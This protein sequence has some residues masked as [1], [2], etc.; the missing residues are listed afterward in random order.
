MQST[1]HIDYE[2]KRHHDLRLRWIMLYV[3]TFS[4][5]L[6]VLYGCQESLPPYEDPRNVLKATISGRY[7]LSRSENTIKIHLNIVNTFDETFE[8]KGIFEGTGKLIS[9]RNKDFVHTFKLSASHWA[10][11]KYNPVTG[12]LT[13]DAGDTLRLIYAWNYLDDQGRDARTMIFSYRV[14][15]T[16]SVRLISLEETF[17]L[18]ARIRVYEKIREIV[19]EPVE[20]SLCHVP[21]WIDPKVCTSL[22]TDL[23]CSQW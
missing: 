20:Y 23:P 11:G 13:M 22:R 19:A 9:K 14:D 17:M 12:I 21:E 3:W 2:G 6:F 5:L 10:R 8:A 18:Q 16:C 7:V 4:L 1:I 15:P